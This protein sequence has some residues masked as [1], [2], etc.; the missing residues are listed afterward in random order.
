LFID[1]DESLGPYAA[2]FFA[3]KLWY[4]ETWY[5]QMSD[6]SYDV[7]EKLGRHFDSNAE[8]SPNGRNQYYRIIHLEIKQI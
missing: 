6:D 2:R 5:L 4:G 3:S 8:G 1:E 7:S